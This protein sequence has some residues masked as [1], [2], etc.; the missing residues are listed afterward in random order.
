MPRVTFGSAI[1]RHVAIPTATVSG[2]TV[3]EALDQVFATNARARG[4]ILDDQSALR[5]HM[6][7]FVDGSLVK[8]RSKLSDTVQPESTIYVVQALS[9]G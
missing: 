8:D 9:G 2:T 3:R 7:I 5:K 4:Y 1:Q 6:A